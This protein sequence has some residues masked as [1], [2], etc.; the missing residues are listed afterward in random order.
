MRLT[1]T[2]RGEK[3]Q[4]ILPLVEKYEWSGD[5]QQAARQLTF[6]VANTPTDIELPKISIQTGAMIRLFDNTPTEIFRGYV[7]TQELT[8]SS[9]EI[10]VTC[11]DGMTYFAHN[12]A[13]YNFTN[14]TPEAIAERICHDFGVSV[15]DII[16]TNV[17]ISQVFKGEALYDIIMKAYT[18]A[19]AVTGIKYMP[20]MW[21]GKFCVRQKGRDTSNYIASSKT[22]IY[23]A[24]YDESIDGMVNRVKIYASNG[25]YLGMVQNSDDISK[26]GLMQDI[27]EKQDNVNPTAAAKAALVRLKQAG[28]INCEFADTTCIVGNAINIKEPYTGLVGHFFIDTDTHTWE[29][30]QATMELTVDFQNLMNEMT[31]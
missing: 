28:K 24:V 25:A 19:S 21:Q 27:Y 20:I 30:G 22:N 4:D 29:S 2:K 9:G 1:Q 6:I 16:K 7:F 17:R 10:S 5:Y 15:G 13:T 31:T 23:D 18:Q 14:T 11:F 26:Y 12:K 8:R 3:E